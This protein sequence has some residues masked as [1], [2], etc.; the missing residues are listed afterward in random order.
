MPEGGIGSSNENFISFLFA[1]AS[2][3][4]IILY[5]PWIIGKIASI[6]A[7]RSTPKKLQASMVNPLSEIW[8]SLTYLPLVIMKNIQDPMMVISGAKLCMKEKVFFLR[9]VMPK[10]IK[11]VFRPRIFVP[12]VWFV[13]FSSTMYSTLTFDAYA[14]LG[15]PKSSSTLEIKKA[16]RTLSKLYHPDL[17]KTE[18]ARG[19]YLQVRRAYK[20]L[21]DREAFEKE[22]AQNIQ[23]YAVG[24][25]LPRFMT[26]GEYNEVVLFGLLGILIALP[27]VVWLKFRDKNEIPKLLHQIR[28]DKELV[29]RFVMHFGIPEDPKYIERRD[30]R[31]TILSILIS[32]RIFPSYASEKAVYHFPPLLDFVQRC[33]DS[34]NN[35]NMILGLGLNEQHIEILHAAMVNNGVEIVENFTRMAEERIAKMSDP[36]WPSSNLLTQSEYRATRYLFKQH[37][38]QVDNALIKLSEELGGANLPSVKKLLNLHQEIYELL[39]LLYIKGN[40]NSKNHIAQLIEIPQRVSNL[41]DSIEPDVQLVYRRYTNHIKKQMMQQNKARSR[42]LKTN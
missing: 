13:L 15:L 17:N 16:Y 6:Y 12:L 27:V 41:V 9:C 33:I 30:S 36:S 26:S 1:I 8:D 3:V 18:E 28:A 23:D 20:A 40:K 42:G 22:E 5:I 25:A 14:I 24:I 10:F 32:L 38:I 19:I 4:L 39:D 37:I 2:V 11:Y 34:D 31:R 29:E 7:Y 21:V 35:R